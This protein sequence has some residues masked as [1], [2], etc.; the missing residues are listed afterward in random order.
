MYWQYTPS[1]HEQKQRSAATHRPQRI[2]KHSSLSLQT[3]IVLFRHG[4]PRTWRGRL[5]DHLTLM[6]R[7]R[8]DMLRA[9]HLGAMRCF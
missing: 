8:I 7:V 1:L 3:D 9:T 4:M 5:I 2:I 6:G